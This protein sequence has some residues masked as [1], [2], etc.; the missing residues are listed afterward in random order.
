MRVN[1][2][3]QQGMTEPGVLRIHIPCVIELSWGMKEPLYQSIE[4]EPGIVIAFGLGL[5]LGLGLGP[6]PGIVISFEDVIENVS[7]L[8]SLCDEA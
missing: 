3:I 8:D 6:G 7:H 1:V 4:L 2:K 5:G